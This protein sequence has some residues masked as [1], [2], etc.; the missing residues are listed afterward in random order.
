MAKLI[1]EFDLHEDREEYE[2]AL[3]G[4]KYSIVLSEIDNW[5]RGLSKYTDQETV[6][7]DEV[8][9]KIHQELEER[10]ISI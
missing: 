1:L 10:G 7:I 9:S 3:N 8:R 5:L 6:S 4:V 2:Y